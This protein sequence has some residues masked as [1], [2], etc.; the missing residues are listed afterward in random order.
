MTS[1]LAVARYAAFALMAVVGPGLAVQRLLRLRPDP[2]LVVPLGTAL[3]A[4]FYW[5][6]LVSGVPTL[7]PALVLLFDTAT[8]LTLRSLSPVRAEREAPSFPWKLAVGPG[9]LLVLL[10]ALTQYPWNRV[11]PSGEF[12][13]DDLVPFDTAF[14]VGLTRELTVGY[15]PQVPGLSGYPLGYHLGTDLVRAAALRWAAVDPFDAISRADVTLGALALML[16]LLGIARRMGLGRTALV[17][18]PWTLFA[19]DFSFVFAGNAQA[20]WWT[21]LL[22]GNVLLSLWLANPMIPALT[23]AL[24]SLVALDRHQA[25]EGRG[26]AGLAALQ[27]AAVPFFKVFMGAHLAIG[28]IAVWLWRRPSRPA[29]SAVLLATLAA[30]AC[31]VL[32]QGDRT[33][34]MVLAPLDLVRTTR[35]T[36]GLEPVGR[37][38]L[39]AWSLGWIAAS[40]GLRLVGLPFAWRALR[41]GGGAATAVAAMA[42]V[43]WP[44]GLLFR[45][46]S[47]E[48]LPG[49]RI[50]NDAGYWLE[51]G[52]PLLWLFT[53]MAADGPLGLGV[54]RWVSIAAAAALCLPSTVQFVIEKAR[55]PPDRIPAAMVRAMGDLA[56]ATRPGE[57]VLQRPGGRYPP[58]PV[59]LV[60]RRV[61]YERFTPWLTQF[62]PAAVL[63]RRHEDVHRFFRT[64]DR[65][66]A[67]SLAHAL[68]ARSLCLYGTDRVRFP[69]LEDFPV[70]HEEPG[71]RCF[72]LPAPTPPGGSGH[73]DHIRVQHGFWRQ[74]G[75]AR[76]E[77]L[78]H[79]QGQEVAGGIHQPEALDRALGEA[80]EHLATRE[81]ATEADGVQPLRGDA[82]RRQVEQDPSQRQEPLPGR[83]QEVGPGYGIVKAETGRERAHQRDQVGPGAQGLAQ[84]AGQGAHVGAGG[85]A[86]LQLQ[87]VALYAEDVELVDLHGL[88]RTVDDH[89]APGQVVETA[90]AH[91][92]GGIGGRDLELGPHEAPAG[93]LDGDMVDG[94]RAGRGEGGAGQVVGGG[95]EAEPHHRAVGLVAGGQEAGQAR[96]PSHAEGKHAGGEGIE[97]A[98]VPHLADAQGLPGAIHHVVRG[99][100]GRLVHHQHAVHGHSGSREG[101]WGERGPV[102]TSSSRRA[103]RSVASRPVS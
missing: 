47:P 82:H 98:G 44:L 92:L 25:G 5:V 29:A 99:R 64:H 19:T 90:A 1:A 66:E 88:R 86:Q 27:A 72:S 39:V 75:D 49:Q 22:R 10:L 71:A 21:D 68:R 40:L 89:A 14:H 79:G 11:A 33:V 61:P 18:L 85:A 38:A 13:L 36:L 70:I 2:A 26:W 8:L 16:A 35:E 102:P 20:H 101:S 76:G 65:E 37:A 45:V 4:L 55:L 30:S 78:G 74:P 97:G 52:G 3:T 62:A 80:A 81:V 58:L 9:L 100:A 53:T 87:P 51:Q 12:L 46:S 48:V 7:F 56:T 69:G 28:L 91:A 73:E 15:P 34:E 31:L 24:G 50:V 41:E 94:H 54:R 60:G 103:T 63:Q 42:L 84:V 59:I 32:G 6:S 57:V 67:L 95:R 23:L 83:G 17:L 43:A 96:A 93:L 77:A